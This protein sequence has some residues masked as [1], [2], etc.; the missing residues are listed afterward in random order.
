MHGRTISS[1]EPQTKECPLRS[2]AQRHPRPPNNST[3]HSLPHQGVPPSHLL[4]ESQSYDTVGNAYFSL[5]IHALPAGWRRLAVVTSAFHMGRTKAIFDHCYGL[6]GALE[7]R[8][9]GSKE[10][11]GDG[12]GEGEGTPS[13]SS[14]SSLNGQNGG[15]GGRDSPHPSRPRQQKNEFELSYHSVSDSGLF[16]PEI[17]QARKAKEAG[18][19]VTWE[20]NAAG[21]TSLK[22]LHRWLFDTHM[23]YAASRQGEFGRQPSLDPVLAAT[24]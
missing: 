14:A 24:Y 22:D 11:D 9:E 19:L 2:T 12:I 3:L 21:I 20:R 23:C 4:K 7:G 16:S 10:G 17:L 1:T 15:C 18:A 13:S 8:G 6:I 5:T